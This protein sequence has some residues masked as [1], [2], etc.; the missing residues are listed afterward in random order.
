MA[1]SKEEYLKKHFPEVEHGTTPCGPKIIVQ[2]RTV[3]EKSAGGIILAEE[4]RDFNNGNT[5]VAKLVAVGAIAFRDRKTG[6][7]WNEG[8]WAE[9]GDV[10]M[11]PKWGGF[12]FEIPIPGTKSN[13]IFAVLDDTNVNLV[14]RENFEAFDKIL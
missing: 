13:A 3:Q 14:I 12:R 9:V 1:L 7:V 11:I 8:A 10:V 5:Q 6:E 4:T 2:L